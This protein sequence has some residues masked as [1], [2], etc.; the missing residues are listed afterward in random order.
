MKRIRATTLA[1]VKTASAL[2]PF[3]PSSV[4]A[5]IDATLAFGLFD[6]LPDAYLFVK[7]RAHRFVHVNAALWRLNGC[8][9]AAGMLGRT[10]FDFFPPALAAQ[11]VA[12]DDRVM[13]QRQPLCDQLWLVPGADGVPLWYLSSKL[14]VI[15][16]DDEVIGI[17]GVMR[18]GAHAGNTPH[19]YARLAPALEAVLTGYGQPLTSADLA[20]RAGLSVSQLQREFQR[21]LHLT[22]SDYLLRVRVLMAR[23]LLERTTR[24]VGGIALDC[25]FYD[26]SHFTRTFRVQTGMTPL[27]YRR[28]FALP[29]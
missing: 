5:Q 18:P 4:L 19:D 6:H 25:G 9:D 21:L 11:Y 27:D 28:R 13:A 3:V 10:D 14:P 8:R 20:R 12:E 26:Q 24:A 2:T 23:R 17:A 22:P 29:A 7:D 15:N 16:A 1:K